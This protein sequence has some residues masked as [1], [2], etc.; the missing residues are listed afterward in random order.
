MAVRT[1]RILDALTKSLD[2]KGRDEAEADEKARLALAAMELS[3]K[4]DGKSEYLLF[5]GQREI[6]SIADIIHEKWDSITALRDGSCRGEKAGQGQES[7]PPRAL[8]PN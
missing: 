3:V 7:R 1:K 8:I 2:E 5:L 4:D 6:A